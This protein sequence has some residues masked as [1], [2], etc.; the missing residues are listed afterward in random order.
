L[1]GVVERDEAAQ[2]ARQLGAI[3]QGIGSGYF[4]VGLHVEPAQRVNGRQAGLLGE[5]AYAKVELVEQWV[6]VVLVG[7]GL[8]AD[9]G[10]A[11]R[12]VKKSWQ[13]AAPLSQRSTAPLV[14]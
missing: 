12:D 9:G 4:D 11:G 1:A 10:R 2:G 5:A 8:A 13:G 14:M 3:E 7:P 6:F